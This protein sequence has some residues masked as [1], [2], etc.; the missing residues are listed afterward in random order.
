MLV[1]AAHKLATPIQQLLY[2][3]ALQVARSELTPSTNRAA[4]SPSV[5]PSTLAMDPCSCIRAPPLCC[6]LSIPC[7]TGGPSQDFSALSPRVSLATTPRWSNTYSTSSVTPRSHQPPATAPLLMADSEML[8][9]KLMHAFPWNATAHVHLA[10]AL[11]RREAYVTSAAATV[12]LQC[13]WAVSTESFFVQLLHITGS[14]IGDCST[15]SLHNTT[16]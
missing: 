14:C 2:P 12:K 13:D 6:T 5:E 7:F 10:M 8:A 3:A 16:I 1:T 11:R 15:Y 4:S 9:R